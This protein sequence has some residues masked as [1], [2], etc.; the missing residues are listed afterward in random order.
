MHPKY[1][2]TDHHIAG[3][4]MGDFDPA[5]VHGGF[6]KEKE[7]ERKLKDMTK[8]YKESMDAHIAGFHEH[9]GKEAPWDLE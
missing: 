3:L 6:R 7:K 9:L 5:D 2:S 1:K 4:H 8:E